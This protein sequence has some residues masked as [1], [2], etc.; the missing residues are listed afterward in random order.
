MY[1]SGH[2]SYSYTTSMKNVI[3]NALLL[4]LFLFYTKD[5][6]KYMQNAKQLPKETQ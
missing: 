6:K 3:D 1:L 4:L 2:V 5:M